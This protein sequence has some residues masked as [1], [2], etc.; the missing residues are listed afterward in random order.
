MSSTFSDNDF[1]REQVQAPV[2]AL[3]SGLLLEK[4]LRL[5]PTLLVFEFMIIIMII[6]VLALLLL[7]LLLLLLLLLL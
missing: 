7:S 1:E 2:D 6:F 3:T 5:P 4:L